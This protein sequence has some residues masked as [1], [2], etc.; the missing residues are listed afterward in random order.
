MGGGVIGIVLIPVPIVGTAVGA[1]VGG[2]SRFVWGAT[3]AEE[4]RAK[5][6]RNVRNYRETITRA[7]E[8]HS[9]LHDLLND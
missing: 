4:R 1:V 7:K 5:V 2:L 6:E 3:K 9:N 8:V